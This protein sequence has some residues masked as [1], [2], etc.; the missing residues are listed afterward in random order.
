MLIQFEEKLLL[1]L[2]IFLLFFYLQLEENCLF[3]FCFSMKIKRSNY[4][5]IFCYSDKLGN[6]VVP[7]YWE[8]AK[9]F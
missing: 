9:L 5:I 7:E 6:D 3:T 1:I 4:N 2:F 8:N